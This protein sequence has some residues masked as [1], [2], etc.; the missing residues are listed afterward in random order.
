MPEG[1]SAASAGCEALRAEQQGDGHPQ[2]VVEGAKR[3]RQRPNSAAGADLP[4]TSDLTSEQK[5]TAV[6]PSAAVPGSA[7]S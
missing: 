3:P 1:L 7:V 6:P 5:T 2:R 4:Q